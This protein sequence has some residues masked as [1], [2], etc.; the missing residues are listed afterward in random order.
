M[1]KQDAAILIPVFRADDGERYLVLVRRSQGGI[2]GGQLAFPG[3]KWD[4]GDTSMWETAL[5]E[6]REEIG[7]AHDRVELLEALPVVQAQT[8]G[9]R[10]FPFL[11]RLVMPVPWRREAHE[12]AD[13]MEI[14][15]RDLAQPEAQGHTIEHFP[16]WPAPKEVPCFRIGPHRLWG[17]SYRILQPLMPRLL[18]G[19]WSVS[20][21][22][23]GS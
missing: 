4:T 22:S 9:F 13:I 21:E 20:P 16:T 14:R 23:R 3:G 7:L 2:H 19:E 12:I 11:V 10:V 15:L 18:A 1:K 17:L 8:T 6:A 5:R